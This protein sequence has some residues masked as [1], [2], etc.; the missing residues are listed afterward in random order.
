MTAATAP[1]S[2]HIAELRSRVI[3]AAIALGVGSIIGFIFNEQVLDFLAQPY[4]D[5]VPGGS[6]NFFRPTEAFSLVM[7]ISLWT[8]VVLASPVILY[9][10]WRFVTPA[11]TRREKK[12][13]IP[14]TGVFVLLFLAGITVGYV[15]LPRGLD[16]LLDFGGDVLQPVIGAD[17]Y[18]RFAMRFLLAFGISFEFPIFIFAAA[19]FGAVNST[20]L[21]SARRWAVVIILVVAAVITPSGD[22]LTLLMLATPMYVFYEVTILCVRFILKK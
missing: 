9:Q 1:F 7:Q 18:L 16:F 3:K 6:L 11:L 21:R 14:L 2:A 20:Q 22:P 15:A 12:W 17:L 5:A 10:I 4:L 8:G 19:A 13:A